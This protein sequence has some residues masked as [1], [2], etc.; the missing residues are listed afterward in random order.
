MNPKIWRYTGQSVAGT[1]HHKSGTPCQDSHRIEIMDD[2]LIAT[3]SD[4]AGSAK[5]SEI[6]SEIAAKEAVAFIRQWK[7]FP[8]NEEEWKIRAD[9]LIRFLRDKLISKADKINCHPKDLAATFLLAVVSETAIAGIQIGDGGI[10]YGAEHQEDLQMLIQP[11][12]S[13]Y[14]NETVF[15][16]SEN[17]EAGLKIAYVQGDIERVALFSDGLQMLALD[18]KTLPAKPHQPFFKPLFQFVQKTESETER[19]RQLGDFLQSPRLCSRTDDDKTLIV[20]IR[21]PS[22]KSPG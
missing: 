21:E 22:D 9:E 6:G 18:M 11:E 7:N 10:V 8:E 2:I 13:E 15:L 4:G 20:A 17:F 14:I 12:R 16:T 5:Y 1:S 19:S 3:V